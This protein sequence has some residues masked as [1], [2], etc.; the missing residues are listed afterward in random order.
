MQ[1]STLCVNVCMRSHSCGLDFVPGGAHPSRVV[2]QSLTFFSLQTWFHLAPPFSNYNGRW[3]ETRGS[4]LVHHPECMVHVSS[5]YTTVDRCWKRSQTHTNTNTN[6]NINTN[7]N[8]KTNTYTNNMQ[9]ICFCKLMQKPPT[10]TFL[11][12]H[13]RVMCTLY[14][15]STHTPQESHL[16]KPQMNIFGSSLASEQL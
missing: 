8:T 1:K 7:S 11:Y 12:V 3:G 5:I 2:R 14:T 9:S 15:K 16:A 4:R 10:Q 13:I 6:S